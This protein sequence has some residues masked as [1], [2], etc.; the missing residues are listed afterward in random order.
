MDISAEPLDYC[1]EELGLHG[2]AQINNR[3]PKK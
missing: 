3:W 1:R 2:G